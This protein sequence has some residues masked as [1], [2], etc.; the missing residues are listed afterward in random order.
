MTTCCPTRKVP[1]PAKGELTAVSLSTA[2]ARYSGR[3]AQIVLMVVQRL[4]TAPGQ[5][6]SVSRPACPAVALNLC[7][8]TMPSLLTPLLSS[9]ASGGSAKQTT[10]P[11]PDVWH[12][13]M[14]GHER[15]CDAASKASTALCLLQIGLEPLCCYCLLV[16]DQA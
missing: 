1:V 2:H 3:D 9:I 7:P 4:A 16:F 15:V 8:H 12:S 10:P 6:A 14:G 11:K 13:M 5:G